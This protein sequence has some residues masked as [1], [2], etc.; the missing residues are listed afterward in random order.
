[1][2][3]TVNGLDLYYEIHGIGFPLVL[4]HGGGS[5]IHST[6][7]RI[8][9]LL[10]DSFK[11]IAV[12]LQAHGRTADRN[13][14]LSFEQDADDVAALLKQLDI[15]KANILGFSNGATTTLQLSIRHKEV[16]EK[17]VLVAA[18]FEKSGMVPE[19]FSGFDNASIEN[20]PSGLKDAFFEVNPDPAAFSTMFERDVARMKA[21]KEIEEATIKSIA[22]PSLIMNND[23]DVVL[24]EHAMRL[25]RL[26]PNS[27]LAIFPGVHGECIGESTTP[28]T[29]EQVE[30]SAAL[31]AGWL[32]S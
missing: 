24:P 2:I 30:Y 3:A 5:T 10:A 4:I 19:L 22:T 1:M 18:I 31:I 6:F 32:Q 27:R 20:M 8:L 29:E 15:D 16:V 12:E 9:P 17:Q 25:F 28:A 26:L 7:G 23:Q 11:I 13:S 14:P 21:F